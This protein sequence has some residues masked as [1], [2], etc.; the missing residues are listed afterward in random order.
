ML[1]AVY[2]TDT[3][4]EQEGDGKDGRGKAETSLI[5]L[6]YNILLVKTLNLGICS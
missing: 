4:V 1:P 3:F 5:V 2:D 6:E